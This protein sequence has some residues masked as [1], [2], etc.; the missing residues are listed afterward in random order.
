MKNTIL[1]ILIGAIPLSLICGI[2]VSII[3]LPLFGLSIL[4]SRLL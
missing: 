2:V 3:G 4:I 1:R